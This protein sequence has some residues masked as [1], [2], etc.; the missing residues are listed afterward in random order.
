MH[1]ESAKN[2]FGIKNLEGRPPSIL[3][4]KGNF[5]TEIPFFSFFLADDCCSFF[6]RRQEAETTKE[7]RKPDDLDH[8]YPVVRV[9]LDP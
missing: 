3:L 6:E 5:L 9:H 7:P 2:S 8:W 1:L 4:K